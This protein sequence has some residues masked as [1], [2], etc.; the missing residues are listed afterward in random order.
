MALR[1]LIIDGKEPNAGVGG[2]SA[3]DFSHFSNRFLT[4]GVMTSGDFLV[5]AQDT[6][7]MTVKYAPG[8]AYV[9]NSAGTMLYPVEE[10]T[11]GNVT[12][13]PNASGND[14]IDTIVIAIDTEADP[15]E[16]A[17]NVAEVVAVQGTPASSPEASTDE[18]IQTELGAGFAWLKLAEVTVENGTVSITVADVSD[19][20]TLVGILPSPK[21]IVQIANAATITP[22]VDTDDIVQITAIAQPFTLANPTG[23]PK[24]GQS[25]IIRIKD[26]GTARAITYGSQYRAIGIPLPTTTVISKSLYLGAIWNATDSKWDVIAVAQ[27]E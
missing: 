8:K 19:Y 20:S 22:N 4:P 26:N 27:E 13:D 3:A 9:P 11:G 1:V 5:E 23:T 6:P 12:I 25:L 14:R 2:V 24:P 16:H 18:E 7:N 21:R 10:D 17:D 15:N